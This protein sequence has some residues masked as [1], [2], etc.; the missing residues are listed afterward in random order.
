MCVP[1]HAIYGENAKVN[2]TEITNE[3]CFINFNDYFKEVFTV[4]TCYTLKIAFCHFTIVFIIIILSIW[5]KPNIELPQ[6][7]TGLTQSV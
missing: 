3:G 1:L 5:C 2:E 4:L 6:S 7:Q